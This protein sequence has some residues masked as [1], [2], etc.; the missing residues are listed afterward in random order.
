MCSAY[1]LESCWCWRRP[2]WLKRICWWCWCS[3]WFWSCWLWVCWVWP[4]CW[5]I[6]PRI[7]S[8]LSIDSVCD[9]AS[10]PRG[11]I[12]ILFFLI[13]WLGLFCCSDLYSLS[14]LNNLTS[15]IV[16]CFILL[17]SKSVNKIKLST[18]KKKKHDSP[19]PLSNARDHEYE[20]SPFNN[21]LKNKK[22]KSSA[23][24]LLSKKLLGSSRDCKVFFCY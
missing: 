11:W 20:H 22:I 8:S 3:C 4:W 2:W 21:S 17:M 19:Y 13:V 15:F 9:K 16:C 14:Y 1:M 24:I 10:G 6:Q 23:S 18:E 7:G 5:D 12:S